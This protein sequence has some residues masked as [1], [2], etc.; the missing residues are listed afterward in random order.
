[1]RPTRRR[2]TW[3]LL[4]FAPAFVACGSEGP[5]PARS[6]DRART[7]PGRLSEADNAPYQAKN[8]EHDNAV[9]TNNPLFQASAMARN[10][11]GLSEADNANPLYS[12]SIV[13]PW[14]SLPR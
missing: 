10:D 14:H 3:F 5:D 9:V 11:G 6:T 7:A 2:A 4:V 13:S 1:M 12:P 8:T